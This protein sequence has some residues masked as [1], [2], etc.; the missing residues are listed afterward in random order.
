MLT[1]LLVLDC[2]TGEQKKRRTHVDDEQTR[3]AVEKLPRSMV[4][5]R[6]KVCKTLS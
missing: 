4:F 5:K 6:G 2:V 1:L 3:K